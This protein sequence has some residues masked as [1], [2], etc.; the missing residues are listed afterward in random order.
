[1][2][3]VNAEMQRIDR[4]A[5]RA[6]QEYDADSANNLWSGAYDQ[7]S[8]LAHTTEWAMH[9]LF[10]NGVHPRAYTEYVERRNRA[11]S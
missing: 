4:Q 1:M 3:D 8:G 11:E 7:L 6:D 9:I 10:E 5:A 2:S